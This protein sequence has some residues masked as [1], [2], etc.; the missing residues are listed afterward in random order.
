MEVLKKY[1]LYSKRCR[2]HF[3][4]YFRV[5]LNVAQ[6]GVIQI[7]IPVAVAAAAVAAAAAAAAM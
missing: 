2:R 5:I 3:L 6:T 7:L 4:R 1:I